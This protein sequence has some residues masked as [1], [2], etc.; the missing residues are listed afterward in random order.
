MRDTQVV[1]G[2]I[3]IIMGIYNCADTL[4]QAIDSILAQTYTNWQLIL[5][6]DC[7]TDNT[8]DIA[9]SYK[10]KHPEKIILIRNPIQV[11]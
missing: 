7:S 5:C 11:V 1:E 4:P 3:S 8:Y 6:D 9:K 10:E 2:Q